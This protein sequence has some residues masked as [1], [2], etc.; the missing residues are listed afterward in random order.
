MSSSATPTKMAADAR[1]WRPEPRE[2]VG[3]PRVRR[4]A[5]R[6]EWDLGRAREVAAQRVRAAG[7]RLQQVVQLFKLTDAAAAKLLEEVATDLSRQPSVLGAHTGARA[8][9]TSAS[10]CLVCEPTCGPP[11]HADGLP[12]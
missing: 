11:A 9:Q 1:P 10:C 5:R 2:A 7:Q 6:A 8:L 3:A 12:V 4:V